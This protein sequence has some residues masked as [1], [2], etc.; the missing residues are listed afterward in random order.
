MYTEP[1]LIEQKDTHLL[2]NRQGTV[3]ADSG[4]YLGHICLF[5]HS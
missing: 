4:R 3:R 5:K 2:L 1:W